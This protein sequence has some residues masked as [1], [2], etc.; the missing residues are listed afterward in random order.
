MITLRYLTR[1]CNRFDQA[2]AA[3]IE[4]YLNG[5]RKRGR[6][7]GSQSLSQD[8]KSHLGSI[9][10][11]RGT[12]NMREIANELYLRIDEEIGHM[13]SVSTVHRVLHSMKFTRKVITIAKIVLKI[14]SSRII[15]FIIF[16]VCWHHRTSRW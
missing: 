13:C 15:A 6:L 3:D 9:L 4:E 1:V 14:L 16:N 10:R 12:R 5:S 7:M 2:E 11:E 8:D